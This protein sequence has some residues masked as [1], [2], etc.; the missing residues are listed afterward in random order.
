MGGRITALARA[1][2]SLASQDDN[3]GISAYVKL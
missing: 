3:A 1:S 2:V